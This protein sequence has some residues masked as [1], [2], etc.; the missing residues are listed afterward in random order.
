MAANLLRNLWAYA[1]I[2]CG[3]FPDGVE[4]FEESEVAG[5]D[6]ARWYLRQLLG[7]AN[8]QGGPALHLL[9][10]NLSHQI[11]HHLFPR[12]PSNRYR[13]AAVEV[14]Q[15]CEKYQLPYNS[16]PL[17]RQLLSVWGKVFRFALPPT[18]SFRS[19]VNE[20]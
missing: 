9:S 20:R 1:V 17:L 16:K 5:E 12:M 3:H 2:F 7:S 19:M 4:E 18:L 8:I 10:G 13:E 15:L 11:E 6:T 14:R